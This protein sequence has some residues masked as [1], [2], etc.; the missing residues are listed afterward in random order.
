MRNRNLMAAYGITIDQFEAM[1]SSQG[2]LCAICD[3]PPKEGKVLYVDHCHKSGKI[4]Q[5]LCIKCNNLLG[6][7]NEN[8]EVLARASTYLKLHKQENNQE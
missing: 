8:L 2:G 5:L 1:E 6:N 4:R 7:C 3:K